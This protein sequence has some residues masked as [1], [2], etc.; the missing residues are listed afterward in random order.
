MEAR[1]RELD[2]AQAQII[3]EIKKGTKDL[4]QSL[5]KDLLPATTEELEAICKNIPVFPIYPNDDGTLERNNNDSK[6]NIFNNS[7][8]KED[9]SKNE[10]ETTNKDYPCIQG[11][12]ENIF[13]KTEI[14]EPGIWEPGP[15]TKIQVEASNIVKESYANFSYPKEIK[16]YQ[17]YQFSLLPDVFKIIAQSG[18]L[19]HGYYQNQHGK[20]CHRND[21]D[22][23]IP[24]TRVKLLRSKQLQRQKLSKTEAPSNTPNDPLSKQAS[25]SFLQLYEENKN[26]KTPNDSMP[27]HVSS[28][29]DK[30]K[31][32]W[33]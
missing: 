28:L 21:P 23:L 29:F 3:E 7:N 18:K 32:K 4:V 27:K 6:N 13:W 30:F 2:L 24:V 1:L 31:F 19:H 17:D 14:W 5:E 22:K 16:A 33:I 26:K 20:L 9:S 15:G 12:N 11:K 10:N 25:L 8:S